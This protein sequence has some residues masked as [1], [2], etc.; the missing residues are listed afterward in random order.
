MTLDDREAMLSR[1]DALWERLRAAL[2]ER[3]DTGAY[4]THAWTGHDVYAHFGR[5]QAHAH[6]ELRR[7]LAGERLSPV[8]GDENAINDAWIA[9]D[10]ALPT[11]VV[12]DRCLRTRQDLRDALT[13]L[14]PEQW[15][16]FGRLFSPDINGEHYEA[17]LADLVPE[18][19]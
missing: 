3:I 2:D 6:G 16:R 11:S 19:T 13:T 14:T 7:V 18:A 8:D 4:A 17:H 9:E 5:W 15:D 1:G 10:R 12:R